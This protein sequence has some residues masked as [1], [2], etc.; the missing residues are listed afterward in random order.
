M[1]E[2]LGASEECQECRGITGVGEAGRDSRYLGARR[3]IEGITGY[4]GTAR[5]CKGVGSHYGDL[6]G[7]QGVSGV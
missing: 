7:H 6:R 3:S 1:L 2:P 5:R 4:W